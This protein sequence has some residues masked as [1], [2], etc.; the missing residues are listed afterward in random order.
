MTL[1]ISLQKHYRIFCINDKILDQCNRQDR[2]NVD[3][4][5]YLMAMIRSKDAWRHVLQMTYSVAPAHRRINM[6]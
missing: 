2:L 6:I 3:C 5:G 1:E 4:R